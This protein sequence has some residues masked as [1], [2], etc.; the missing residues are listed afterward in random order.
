MKSTDLLNR[1][2]GLFGEDS[3]EQFLNSTVLVLGLGGVG[4]TCFEAL[5]RSG[6]RHLIG[7]D[8]DIVDP[9]NLNRQIL[10]S[11]KDIGKSKALIAK[12]RVLTIDPESNVI[13][14]NENVDDGFFSRH[15][16]GN[17]DFVIDAV[18]DLN[19]KLL[20]AKHC[21]DNHI[22][23]ACSMGMALRKDPTQVKMGKLASTSVDPLAKAFRKLC[24]DAGLDLNAIDVVYS[25]ESPIPYNG[26]LSS[27]M[28]VPSSAGLALA[29]LALASLS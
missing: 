2:I 12:D 24:R 19:A 20:I 13:A 26:N 14:I 16:F 29:Y 15:D 3:V 7:V 10:F 1:T 25:T 21:L 8:R 18:D 5:A 4:G 23:F 17:I 9:T 28:G 27:Y 22:R 11:E 6:V